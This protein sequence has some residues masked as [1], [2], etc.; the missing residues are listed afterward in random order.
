MG[1][2]TPLKRKIPLCTMAGAWAG[3][4]PPLIGWSAA[5][6]SIANA[7]AWRLYAILFFWQFPHFMAIAWMY[8]ED[9]AQAGY[10]VLP[11]RHKNA[12]LTCLTAVP[13]ILP[14]LASF[15][16]T[17]QADDRIL[18][19]SASAILGLGLLFYV[20]RQL[21]ARS[22]VAARQLLKATLAYLLLQ[23]LLLTIAKG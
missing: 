15:T 11:E 4:M 19:L 17:K 12:F 18:P 22:N 6:G 7:Q 9:Y 10:F 21:M 20:T 8:R 5:S 23:M 2:C 13:S 3:A 1:M 14:L 16:A